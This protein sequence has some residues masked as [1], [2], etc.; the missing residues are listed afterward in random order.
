MNVASRRHRPLR[1]RHPLSPPRGAA[2]LT[3]MANQSLPSRELRHCV[4]GLLACAFV[5]LA[6]LPKASA[7]D[8]SPD[9]APAKESK[10]KTNACSKTDATGRVIPLN[11]GKT[12]DDSNPCTYG[13]T[14]SGGQCQGGTIVM[15]TSTSCA[16]SV[17]TGTATC[18][19][20]ALPD[21][22][23]CG[24]PAGTCK[25]GSCLVTAPKLK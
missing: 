1:G 7:D 20:T 18:A 19:V 23:T 12:C 22:T 5:G 11:D 10:A 25:A 16:T 13:E 6:M 4:A 24:P 17:C 14:C 21:G 15:C 2:T 9:V 8:N 3:T